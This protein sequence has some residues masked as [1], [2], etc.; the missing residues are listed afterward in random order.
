[1][2][3]TLCGS[4]RYRQ[5]FTDWNTILTLGGHTIYG[6]CEAR[7]GDDECKRRLDLVHLDKIDHS[8][9]IVVLNVDGYIGDSTLREIEWAKMKRKDIYYLENCPKD[10]GILGASVWM[11]QD[12]FAQKPIINITEAKA[13]EL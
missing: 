9:A 3:I 11:L 1:M 6:N 5:A 2:R 12:L 10:K 7:C 4:M 8:D 13:Y